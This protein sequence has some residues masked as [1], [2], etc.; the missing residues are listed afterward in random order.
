MEKKHKNM[1]FPEGL[2]RLGVLRV[3][4]L[5]CVLVVEFIILKQS[6]CPIVKQNTSW[7]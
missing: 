7:L 2:L 3:F 6:E 4:V 5:F 1:F